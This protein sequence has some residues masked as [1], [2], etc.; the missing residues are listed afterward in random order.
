MIR[1]IIIVVLAMAMVGI[2][3]LCLIGLGWPIVYVHHGDEV[4]VRSGVLY[5]Y[6]L[7]VPPWGPGYT[8]YNWRPFLE[9]L[10]SGGGCLHRLRMPLWVPF[11][12]FAPYP[13]LAFFRGP[14]RRYRRRKRGL[15]VNCGYNLTGNISGICPECGTPIGRAP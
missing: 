15:C 13:T 14:V 7:H 1:K 3:A 9:A 12:I 10:L 5:I 8:Q 2:V 4:S 11:L 6:R